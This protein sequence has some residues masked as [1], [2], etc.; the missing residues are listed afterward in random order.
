MHAG[1]AHL[2]YGRARLRQAAGGQGFGVRQLGVELL[3]APARAQLAHQAD[4]RQ[5]RHQRMRQ[6]VMQAARQAQALARHGRMARVLRQPLDACGARR[7][8][9]VQL[10]V[11]LG[12]GRLLVLP[13]PVIGHQAWNAR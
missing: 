3:A 2:A 10:G 7:H 12:Q 11:E 5:Q 13:M 1:V 8:A 9:G 4:L 6:R